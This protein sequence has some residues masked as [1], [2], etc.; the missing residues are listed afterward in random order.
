MASV[1][2]SELTKT[3]PGGTTAAVDHFNL[4]IADGEF[5]CLVGPSG[6]GKTTVLRMIAGLEEISSGTVTIGDRVVNRLPPRDRD[7][8]LVFQS[9]ALYPHMS[10]YEN[11]SF[12]LR[13][14]KVP[15]SDVDTAVQ[16]AARIL[17][18]G[19]YLDRKPAQ[20][21]GGQRQRV[22]LGRAIVRDPAAFLMDE[23]LSNLD[24]KLRVQTRAEI[25][26]LHQRLSATMIYV[27]HDQVEAMTMADRIAVISQGVLEQAGTPQELYD[28]PRNLFVA[29]FIGSP[30]MNFLAVQVRP[31]EDTTRLADA[32]G[33]TELALEGARAAALR[34]LGITT[35]TLGVRPEHLR[36]G[37][38]AGAG[39][40]INATVDV[41]EFLGNDAH[42]HVSAGAHDLVATV[43]ARQPLSVGEAVVLSADAEMVYLFDP[44][45]GDA[46]YEA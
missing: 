41:I 10:V 29:G 2:L 34:R 19:D 42:V 36:V 9:Y 40:A 38:P 14:R 6:C 12:G 28:R 7:I 11:M 13:L 35:A 32:E 4:D 16:S 24:A 44:R 31:D 3:Y 21:S 23:P 46:I 26:R 1:I 17:D 15:K 30:A 33:S 5:V 45:S 8:A 20:L 25:V 27:T 39:L 43:S 37:P 18:L 22:A